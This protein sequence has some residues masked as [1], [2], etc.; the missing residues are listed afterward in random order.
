MRAVGVV[1][2]AVG[3]LEV[4]V[5]HLVGVRVRVSVV[6]VRVGKLEVVVTHPV[7]VKV[8]DGACE[9][10]EEPAAIVLR[11]RALLLDQRL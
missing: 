11:K 4:A 2:D 6:R 3:K 1:E 8:G 5:T 7:G 10:R 9:L